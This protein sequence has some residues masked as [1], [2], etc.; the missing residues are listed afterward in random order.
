MVG[1]VG[2]ALSAARGH[3]SV[4]PRQAASAEKQQHVDEVSPAVGAV[5]L[6]ASLVLAVVFV[7]WLT[8]PERMLRG[9]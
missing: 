2:V 9:R 8:S 7:V 1:S 3:V 5:L 4:K 6:I